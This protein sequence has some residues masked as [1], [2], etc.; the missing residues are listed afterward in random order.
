M[1]SGPGC[2]WLQCNPLPRPRLFLKPVIKARWGD[3]MVTRRIPAHTHTSIINR[4]R[5]IWL[6]CAVSA[7]Y[8]WECVWPNRWKTGSDRLGERSWWRHGL[9]TTSCFVN[10]EVY[11]CIHGVDPIYYES[12]LISLICVEDISIYKARSLV[13]W[14]R[15]CEKETEIWRESGSQGRREQEEERT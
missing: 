15:K 4:R 14:G 8:M 3:E 10:L 13:K 11:K 1:A 9:N 5:D 12:R 2:V 7:A 6:R